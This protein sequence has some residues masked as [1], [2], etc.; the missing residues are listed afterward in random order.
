MAGM[1]TGSFANIILDYIFLFPLAM[2][3]F[4]AALATGL[5]LILSIIVLSFHFMTKKNTMRLQRCMIRIKQITN[6]IF[7]GSSALVSELSF[8]ITLITFNLV[9]LRIA[10]NIGVAAYGIVANIAIVPLAIFPGVA[11]GIQPLISR[12]HGERNNVLV[13]QVLK[14]AIF[15][16]AALSLII[17]GAAYIHAANIV[18]LFNSEGNVTL[19]A[20]AATGIKIYF[21]GFI[22]AAI[23]IIAAAFFSAIAA[24]KWGL[25]ISLLR[26]AVILVPMVILLSGIFQ[27]N[28]I[29]LSFIVTEMIVSILS[30]LLLCKK[31]KILRT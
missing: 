12:G 22:F 16:V 7:L 17:Y 11:Q 30:V 31:I 25:T 24:A 23:N 5:S 28:G 13:M 26:G 14:Y 2:G 19:A 20:L 3:M 4:G 6:I 10:G 8:A 15:L 9:I 18:S 27:M 29:W 21:I 1:V